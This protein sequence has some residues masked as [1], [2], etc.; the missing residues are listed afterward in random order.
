MRPKTKKKKMTTAKWK[1]KLWPHF[2]KF[3]RNRDKYVCFTCGRKGEGAG[4]H[5]GHF[6]HRSV[7]GL[8]L[9]FEETNVHAQ[10]YHCNINLG[11]NG[12]VYYMK[13]VKKYGQEHVDDLFRRKDRVT[14]KDL[15]WDELWE[16]Y[17]Q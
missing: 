16:K 12:A 7:G 3:I 6:I 15:P 11:S 5:A 14:T 9:Y 1:R 10:C 17:A 2:S 13:M 8:G 4:M